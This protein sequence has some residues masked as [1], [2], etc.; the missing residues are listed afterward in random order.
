MNEKK[1]KGVGRHVP[2]EVLLFNSG[3]QNTVDKLLVSFR[4]I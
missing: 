1:K 3:K 4:N 2:L